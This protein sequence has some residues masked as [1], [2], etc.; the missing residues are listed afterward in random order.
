MLVLKSAIK[1]V[2][3]ARMW[4]I[5]RDSRRFLR[6]CRENAWLRHVSAIVHVGANTGEE[7]NLYS[8]FK[9]HVL[10]IEPIP[11]VFKRLRER[12]AS[13]PRQRALQRL[14]TDEDGKSCTFHLADNNG[15]AS[16]IFTFQDHAEVFPGVQMNSHL[17]LTTRASAHSAQFWQYR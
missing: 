8:F 16:S 11:D 15:E 3:P 13:H 14:V 10:W 5:L 9:V 4:N 7:A 6:D 17:A 12:I 1:K 2:V